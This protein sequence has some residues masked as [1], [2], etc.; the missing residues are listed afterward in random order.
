[1]VAVKWFLV[2]IQYF[3]YMELKADSLL[4]IT[5]IGKREILTEGEDFES[6]SYRKE[7]SS[8]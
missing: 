7:S 8:C 4:A 5:L 6:K 3:K 1:M 2:T